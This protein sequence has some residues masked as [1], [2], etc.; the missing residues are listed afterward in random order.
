MA[1]PKSERYRILIA[2]DSEMCCGILSLVLKNANYDVI[3][4]FDGAQA[5]EAVEALPFD[6][7]IL[8]H[9]MPVLNGLGALEK[10]REFRP[11]LPVIV[12]S[13]TGSDELRADYEKLGVGLLLTKPINPLRL[14]TQVSQA[15]ETYHQCAVIDAQPVPP[16]GS[17]TPFMTQ[18]IDA[19]ILEKPI[20]AGVSQSAQK[21]IEGFIRIRRFKV[22]ATIEGRPG[23]GLLDIAVAMAETKEALLLVCPA[24]EVSERELIMLFAPALP[25]QR[26]VIL[27]VT[28]SELLTAPQQE[29]LENLFTG[30]GALDAYFRDKVS[31]ILCAESSLHDLADA[32]RFDEHL[33]MRTGAMSLRLTDLDKR[34]GDICIIARAVMRRIGATR[35]K[36]TQSG[37]LWL[38]SQQ[39]PG[40][41][42]QLHRTIELAC[43]VDLASDEIDKTH[44]ALA[45]AKEPAHRA[46]LFHDMLLAS[47]YEFTGLDAL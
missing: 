32:G 37:Q 1:H 13:G 33:L 18:G 30:Q 4:V 20:F 46:A 27:I 35:I 24:A 28:N 47:L 26:P 25:Q 29:A 40:D 21:L 9:E 11:N 15:I 10:I 23:T 5:V 45:Y 43:K 12:C 36:L 17:N 3:C 6:L 14:K 41:Y 22:A 39:W 44:L 42:R 16:G 2:D 19:R 7:V 31:L 38:E 34:Q 8:D